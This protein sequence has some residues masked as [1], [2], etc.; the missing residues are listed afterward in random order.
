MDYYGVKTEAEIISGNIV[1]LSIFHGNRKHGDLKETIMYAVRSLRK[2]AR[3]WF[4]N[5][6]DDYQKTATSSAD[7][8]SAR[9]SAWYHVTYHPD[10]WGHENLKGS[11]ISDPH[12][13][14][15][16]WVIY[17]KLLSIKRKRLPHVINT[18]RE[19]SV[20]KLCH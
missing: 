3:G 7:K 13:I 20:S 14:S 4:E 1:T 9:A 5:S 15:F 6:D 10:Y 12:F 18:K 16:P 17:D 2:E 8:Q 19:A 11:G